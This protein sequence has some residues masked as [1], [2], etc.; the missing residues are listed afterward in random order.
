MVEKEI[1]SKVGFLDELKVMYSL[2]S[3]SGVAFSV[4]L[5]WILFLLGIELF[6]M[7]SKIGEIE[8]DYDVTILHQMDLQKKKLVL[9]SRSVE[10]RP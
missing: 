2:I 5:L 9:L 6:I 10:A 4:W 1:N 8:T 7:I 3:E